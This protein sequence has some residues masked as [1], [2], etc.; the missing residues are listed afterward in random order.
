MLVMGPVMLLNLTMEES[1]VNKQAATIFIVG[2]NAE[3][4]EFVEII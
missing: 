2:V 1:I 3:D 4:E